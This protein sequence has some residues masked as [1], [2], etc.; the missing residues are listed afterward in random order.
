MFIIDKILTLQLNITN[1]AILANTIRIANLEQYK[2][3]CAIRI[4]QTNSIEYIEN[5]NNKII[6]IIKII[7]KILHFIHC[8]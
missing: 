8:Q 6:I 5:I 1:K 3:V 4:T 7:I 2:L